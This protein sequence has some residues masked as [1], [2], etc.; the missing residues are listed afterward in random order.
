MAKRKDKVAEVRKNILIG[1]IIVVAAVA[2]IG[3]YYSLGSGTDEPYV[4]L[5]IPEG[6]GDV[7]VVVYFSYTCPICRRFE[8]LL[9]DWRE[10]LPDGVSFERS[11]IAS[12]PTNRIFAKAYLALERHS[13]ADAN[14]HRIFRAIH[15]RNRRFDSAEAIA[16][17]VDGFDIDRDT[18]LRTFASPR[19]SRSVSA[20]EQRFVA[21]GLFAVPALVVD[22]KYIIN[23]SAG[24]K[25]AVHAADDLVRELLA[26][27]SAAEDITP[28]EE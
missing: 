4:T 26:Q 2:A 19:I 7:E 8:E 21:A 17:F 5:D 27:R 14:Q 16:D 18:F 24:R 25:Q 1:T 3:L 22:D 12:S 10:D 6:T 15:D 23:M 13:A 11:H 28:P 20:S 9:D